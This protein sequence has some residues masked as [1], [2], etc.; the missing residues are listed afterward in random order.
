MDGKLLQTPE[1]PPAQTPGENQQPRSRLGTLLWGSNRPDS[2]PAS[3]G[4]SQRCVREGDKLPKETAKWEDLSTAR[5]QLKPGASHPLTEKG[6]NLK[7]IEALRPGCEGGAGFWAP[8]HG[9]DENKL[10]RGQVSS[11]KEADDTHFQA[12]L[13][14]LERRESQVFKAICVNF[15]SP[16]SAAETRWYA[17]QGKTITN[18]GAGWRTSL[19]PM[20]PASCYITEPEGE[21]HI[22][23]VIFKKDNVKTTDK[24]NPSALFFTGAGHT[25][26]WDL[27]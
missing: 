25:Q 10:S 2:H 12:A 14:R 20:A 1:P 4:K 9:C 16:G 27:S 23:N 15:K 24:Q 3:P 8:G 22:S 19:P 5:W 21:N 18:Q 26:G 13:K 17:N 6:R 11:F 7:K